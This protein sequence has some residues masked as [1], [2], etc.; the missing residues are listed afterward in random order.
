MTAQQ[1]AALR[2]MPHLVI[3]SELPTIGVLIVR[4]AGGKLYAVDRNGY[5]K[6]VRP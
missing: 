3:V 2:D 6:S 4:G 5:F 1:E